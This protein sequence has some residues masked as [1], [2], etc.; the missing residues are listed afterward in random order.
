MSLIVH[1]NCQIVPPGIINNK[2]FK[3]QHGNIYP[4]QVETYTDNRTTI[5]WELS[6]FVPLDKEQ[7]FLS[8]IDRAQFIELRSAELTMNGQ[9]NDRQGFINLKTVYKPSNCRLFRIG[10]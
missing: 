1:G 6:V 10:E 4:I 8:K 9:T 2:I 5:K 7:E 3:T